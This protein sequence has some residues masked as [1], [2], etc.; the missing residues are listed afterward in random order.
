M[1][2]SGRRFD[3]KETTLAQEKSKNKSKE[4]SGALLNLGEVATV[5]GCRGIIA[6]IKQKFVETKVAYL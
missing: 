3:Q 6:S 5:T 2:E 1:E 4:G